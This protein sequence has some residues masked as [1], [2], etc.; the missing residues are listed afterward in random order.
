M[1]L[2]LS[3]SD[4][5]YWPQIKEIIC[6]G[7]ALGEFSQT[8]VDNALKKIKAREHGKLGK[9]RISTLPTAELPKNI[10]PEIAPPCAYIFMKNSVT[11]K[12]VPVSDNKAKAFIFCINDVHT[13]NV[14]K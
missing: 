9:L 2:Y 13:V 14:K 8:A 5:K 6:N 7:N 3:P 10:I 11:V 12:K 1:E 4:R